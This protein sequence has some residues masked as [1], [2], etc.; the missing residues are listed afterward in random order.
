MECRSGV[1]DDI[2]R[3]LAMLGMKGDEFVYRL[4]RVVK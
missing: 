4:N 2:G 3:C 1:L